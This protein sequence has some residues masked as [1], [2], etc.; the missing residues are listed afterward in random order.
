MKTPEHET[1]DN[2]KLNVL[3]RTMVSELSVRLFT[4][5]IRS[6]AMPRCV[7]LPN[8]SGR[9][10]G[11]TLREISHGTVLQLR[12]GCVAGTSILGTGSQLNLPHGTNS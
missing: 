1:G 7:V 6:T 2:Y 10:Y 3:I 9:S 5:C 12:D 4:Y 8:I 11:F